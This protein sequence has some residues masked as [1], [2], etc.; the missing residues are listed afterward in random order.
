MIRALFLSVFFYS[1]FLLSN[2]ELPYSNQWLK[3]LRYQQ[4]HIG[5]YESQVDAPKF[6][7][8]EDGKN[9]PE[10]EFY[11]TIENLEKNPKL[12]CDFPARYLLLKKNK[13]LEKIKFTLANCEEYQY[14]LSHVDL[15]S[16]W[17]VFSS[18]Y[19]NRPASAFGHTFL[20]L[21]SKESQKGGS[22][23]LDFGIDYSA[24][25]GNDNALLY[26][27]KGIIG[28][29][30][31]TF[32]II[33]FYRKVREYSDYESRDLWEYK[34]K[35]N[36]E[37]K[38]FFLAH[39]WEMRKVYFDY[40]YFSE[41]CS[42]QILTLIQA[43]KPDVDLLSKLHKII[44]PVDTIF[45]LQDNKALTGDI[46]F[47]PSLFTKLDK[48]WKNL[49]SNEKE[50][51][52]KLIETKNFSEIKDEKVLDTYIDY[53]DFIHS[54]ELVDRK[55]TASLEKSKILEHRSHLK[56]VPIKYSYKELASPLEGHR[57][58]RVSLQWSSKNHRL[59]LEYKAALHRLHDYLKGYAP[60]MQMD[61]GRVFV[62]YDNRENDFSIRELLLLKIYSLSPW[63]T[64][65]KKASFNISAS[66]QDPYDDDNKHIDGVIDLGAGLTFRFGDLLMYTAFQ[67]YFHFQGEFDLTDTRYDW[68][69]RVLFVYNISEK[70]RLNINS[71]YL[72]VHGFSLDKQWKNTLNVNYA[73]N[74]RHASYFEY[75][76][77]DVSWSQNN[78]EFLTLGYRFFF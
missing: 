36:D 60:G 55:S 17:L 27:V 57:S 37:E 40:F 20:R 47:R 66:L 18:Y 16:V 69:P 25:I 64:I 74:D 45:S 42:Y 62:E 15:E 9:N 33:P 61:M 35:F 26:S 72:K 48:R 13:K 63:S 1:S 53:Y 76:N 54:D 24:N 44:V 59:G 6:F 12:I 73:F 29:Y 58:R 2:D 43:I 21:Q 70:W 23:L 34:V 4:T 22:D 32:K 28:G 56:K 38:A 8:A 50:K 52:S 75:Q 30:K 68:G 71:E 31:G 11:K 49:E 67:Q 77:Y 3:L 10:K 14:Y 5:Y 46:R 65:N 78:L 7:F 51:F 19:I 39:L 41:N